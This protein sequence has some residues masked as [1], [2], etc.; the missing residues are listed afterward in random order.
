[1]FTIQ[2]KRWFDRINGNTYH[3]VAIYNGNEF[4]D[5]NPFTYGYD[6]H[7]RQT[8]MELLQNKGIYPKTDKRL[9]SGISKDEYD[10]SNWAKKNC[11]FLCVD[12]SRKKDL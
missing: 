4:V 7:Y 11:L 1:M 10:F 9:L 6:E 12:V 8:A 3:S 5:K 2:A